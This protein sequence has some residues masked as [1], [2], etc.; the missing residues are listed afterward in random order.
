MLYVFKFRIEG[1]KLK[2]KEHTRKYFL[3]IK[4]KISL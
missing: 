3:L 2:F 4:S 1:A